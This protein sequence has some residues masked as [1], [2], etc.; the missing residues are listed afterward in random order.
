MVRTNPSS[1]PASRNSRTVVASASIVV[2]PVT[3]STL[4]GPSARSESRC[5]TFAAAS[6]SSLGS[7]LK[8]PPGD[9]PVTIAHVANVNLSAASRGGTSEFS[10]SEMACWFSAAAAAARFGSAGLDSATAFGPA[11]FEGGGGGGTAPGPAGLEGGGGAGTVAALWAALTFS[12][13]AASATS[14]GLTSAS[15][16]SIS[17]AVVA[18]PNSSA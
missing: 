9:L 7:S 10:A 16:C 17:S 18:P 11:G 12:S 3:S 2:A 5:A 8:M 15:R 6:A 13:S 1:S 4:I 14:A